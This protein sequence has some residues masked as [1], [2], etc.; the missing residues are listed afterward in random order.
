MGLPPTPRD[1]FKEGT[2]SK[3]AE[4]PCPSPPNRPANLSPTHEGPPA[5]P[6]DTF[7]GDSIMKAKSPTGQQEVQLD[8]GDFIE[9]EAEGQ[10]S[11]FPD[12]AIESGSP[13]KKMLEAL[14]E[15]IRKQEK[16]TKKLKAEN[17]KL[18]EQV[19]SQKEVAHT[20]PKIPSLM[21]INVNTPQSLYKFRRSRAENLVKNCGICSRKEAGEPVTPLLVQEKII[22]AREAPNG[23]LSY[24]QFNPR[25][26]YQQ[27]RG[28]WKRSFKGWLN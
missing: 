14:Q 1:P 27:R 11:E 6:R 18:K 25:R 7:N 2:R 13:M 28:P 12:D 17:K 15:K 23:G 9:L 4:D 8:E 22:Q 24:R 20:D 21:N 3:N 10:D 5:M 26:G 16:K 19:T